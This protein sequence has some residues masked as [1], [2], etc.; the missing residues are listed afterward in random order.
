M[1]KLAEEQKV[2]LNKVE[3]LKSY[4]KEANLEIS[5]AELA[6]SALQDK[7]K[8]VAKLIDSARAYD[9]DSKYNDL[10]NDLKKLGLEDSPE[11]SGIKKLADKFNSRI[12]SIGQGKKSVWYKSIM[13][14][15]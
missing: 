7:A 4:A 5:K 13:K 10:Y 2:E 3:D 14:I 1:A 15:Y 9:I 8:Q 12:N 11:L 6:A